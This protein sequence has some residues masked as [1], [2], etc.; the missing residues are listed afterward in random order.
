MSPIVFG[1]SLLIA[2]I[3]WI[4]AVA[5]A[6]AQASSAQRMLQ[7]SSSAAPAAPQHDMQHMSTP[8]DGEVGMSSAREGSG[9]SWLPDE[10]PG[11]AVHSQAGGWMLMAHL[12]AFGQYLHDAGDRGSHQL[13]SINWFMGMADRTVGAGHLGLRGMVSLEPWTIRG[14]G[15]SDLLASGEV[16]QGEAIHDRQH[17]HDLFMELAATYDRPLA[18]HVRLQVYGGPAGEPAL[19]PTAFP[20]RISAMPSPLAPI[21]HHWFDA[22]HVTFGVATAGVYGARWKAE[23]SVFN[24]REPDEHRTNIDFAPLDSYSGRVW[25]LPTR[26]WALQVS[27][28]RL[29]EAEAGHEGGPRVDVDRLTA[30]A[31]YHRRRRAGSVW[32]STAGWGRNHEPGNSAT[33]AFLAET[34][35]TFD[36]RDAWFG[37]IEISGKSGHDLAIASP[38][39]FTVAK[40]GA[41]YT[42]YV[43]GR[44]GLKPG[45]GAGL[46]AGIVPEALQ[47]VYGGRVTF[48]FSVFVTLRPGDR[49]M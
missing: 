39:V 24:A 40:I 36:D 11:Y 23:T 17:P 31:T 44:K 25:F 2:A 12:N 14:C 16:C 48:G 34:N 8:N 47:R 49:G 30:S 21:T 33:N 46:S 43:D 26:Q 13:G 3:I 38:D 37:R 5:P 35:L 18:G 29:A 10:T 45:F 42:R 15:Y 6:A 22:T 27:A 20:H 41:G 9:T 19:G 7:S 28:G 32:A 4:A 1:R